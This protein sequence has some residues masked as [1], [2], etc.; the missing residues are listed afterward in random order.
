MGLRGVGGRE[1]RMERRENVE[2]DVGH[3]RDQNSVSEVATCGG[4]ESK[5]E[6]T[7]PWEWA[8]VTG[9][10]PLSCEIV[11]LQSTIETETHIGALD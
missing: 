10:S 7:R 1:R 8:A 3:I 9:Q 5:L 11:R 4:T 2:A 6:D